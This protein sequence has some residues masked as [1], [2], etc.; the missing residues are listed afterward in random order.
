MLT[1]LVERQIAA[2]AKEAGVA[3]EQA[4]EELLCE[5]QPMLIFTTPEQIG[6]LAVFLCTDGGGDDNRH[7]RADRWW[8]DGAVAARAPVGI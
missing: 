2:R 4:K 3:M 5:K 7:R 8:V 6:A 1:P